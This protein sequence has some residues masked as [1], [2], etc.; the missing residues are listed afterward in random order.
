MNGSEDEAPEA[1][2]LS[3]GKEMALLQTQEELKS[4]KAFEEEKK[5]RAKKMNRSDEPS[6][7][8]ERSKDKKETTKKKEEVDAFP[9]DLL[10]EVNFEALENE[11]ERT[12][13]RKR[14]KQEIIQPKKKIFGDN[15]QVVARGSLNTRT[16]RPQTNSFLTDHFSK[17]P[18]STLTTLHSHRRGAAADVFVK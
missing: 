11:P 12:R 1:I 6:K 14:Q 4:K 5:L 10:S 13:K 15:I 9:E 7:K 17:V 2:S 3:S 18:R 8:E 16:I